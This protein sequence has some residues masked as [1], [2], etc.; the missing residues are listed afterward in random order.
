MVNAVPWVCRIAA[1]CGRCGGALRS[2][3][4]GV[5]PMPK[6][7]LTTNAIC[8]T[9]IN[10][11]GRRRS[12][13]FSR[14]VS[15]T[16]TTRAPTARAAAAFCAPAAE[17]IPI[18]TLPPGADA[19]QSSARDGGVGC[20]HFS[21]SVPLN[22]RTT[23][24]ETNALV[25][26][27]RLPPDLSCGDS[28][29]PQP[30]SQGGTYRLEILLPD[31]R[32]DVTLGTQVLAKSN[33]AEQGDACHLLTTVLPRPSRTHEPRSDRCSIS[34][35]NVLTRQ[36]IPVR[37]TPSGQNYVQTAVRVSARFALTLTLLSQQDMT[38]AAPALGADSQLKR[39]GLPATDGTSAGT[40][41]A[42]R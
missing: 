35:R 28:P 18:R 14:S 27:A 26:R 21:H 29:G 16:T 36:E 34:R 37:K 15:P 33:C 11:A 32:R 1:I 22:Q 31:D 5:H 3:L 6:M 19:C 8:R 42:S 10:S 13:S 40:S 2:A 20:S 12:A 38:C 39:P 9:V 23:P 24:A 41:P 25:A 7:Y 30:A 4:T 17:L